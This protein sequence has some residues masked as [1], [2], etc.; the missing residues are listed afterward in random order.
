M[1]DAEQ[2]LTELIED[3]ENFGNKFIF[4]INAATTEEP[5]SARAKIG[6]I[7]FGSE[8][9]KT[10]NRIESKLKNYRAGCTPS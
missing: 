6:L 9:I 1:I 10:L 4:L 3:I 7:E 2:K 8:S 5:L